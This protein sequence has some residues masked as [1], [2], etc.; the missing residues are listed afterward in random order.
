MP[1]KALGAGYG[2]DMQRRGRGGLGKCY[3]E[4][5]PLGAGLGGGDTKGAVARGAVVAVA[6]FVAS[7]WLVFAARGAVVRGDAMGNIEARR[8]IRTVMVVGQ[9]GSSLHHYAERYYG[10]CYEISH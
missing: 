3:L 10:P 8:P 7:L 5:E 4:G 9:D 2:K 1:A 6:I